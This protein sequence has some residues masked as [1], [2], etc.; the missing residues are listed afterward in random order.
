MAPPAAPGAR[1]VPTPVDLAIVIVSY[2]TRD[3]LRDCLRSI[4]PALDGLSAQVFVVDNNSSDGSPQMVAEEYPSVD[5][6]VN[7]TNAGFAAANNQ[8]LARATARYVLLLNPDTE[9]EPGSLRT[10]V[11]F[12][13][14]H[15]EAGAC[16]PMLLNTDGSLQKSGARFPTLWSEFAGHAGIWRLAPRWHDLKLR[17]GRDDFTHVAE[18][19]HVSG[20]CLMVRSDVMARVGPLDERFFMFYEEVEWCLRIKRA[21]WKVYYVPDARVTHHW[22]GS[23]RHASKAMT[24]QLFR[25]QLLYHTKRGGLLNALGIRVVVAIGLA[26]NEAL[27][28]GVAVKRALRRI[29]FL[30]GVKP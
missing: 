22:M 28:A 21:G 13:D 1:Q 11:E 2:N 3:M 20:A 4:G 19:D 9:A 5:L 23:V 25:S 29:G 16:G 17:W 12:L 24:A 7:A 8:A 6:T 30:P 27:Y 14:A 26:K 18:V 15:P 10:M